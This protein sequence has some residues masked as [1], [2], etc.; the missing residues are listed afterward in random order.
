MGGAAL[1][2]RTLLCMPLWEVWDSRTGLE[3][4]G[5]SMISDSKARSKQLQPHYLQSTRAGS[6]MMHAVGCSM[7]ALA[8]GGRAAASLSRGQRQSVLIVLLAGLEGGGAAAASAGH[9][10]R[11]TST[12][13][14][15]DLQSRSQHAAH[16]R[17]CCPPHLFR[18][19][20][21]RR[22]KPFLLAR[23]QG[24]NSRVA[25]V[26]VGACRSSRGT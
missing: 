16:R 17:S 2:A 18:H 11:L 21:G 14:P 9:A 26:S 1:C 7:S 19:Q 13:A 6:L 20:L 10:L 24:P 15:I 5:G 12:G 4:F 25:K 22:T 23:R 8:C 3:I